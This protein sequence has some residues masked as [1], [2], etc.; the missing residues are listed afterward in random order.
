M[1]IGNTLLIDPRNVGDIWFCAYWGMQYE[2]LEKAGEWFRVK[3][4][5]GSVTNHCTKL[6]SRDYI[7]SMGGAK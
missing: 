6:D 1:R 5:D 2:I 3:W 4:A 7:V